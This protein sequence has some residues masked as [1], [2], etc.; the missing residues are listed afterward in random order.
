[1][2][3]WPAAFS[4]SALRSRPCTIDKTFPKRLLNYS[5]KRPPRGRLKR[6]H[7][8]VGGL[9]QGR[10]RLQKSRKRRYYAADTAAPPPP[11]L[12]D[13]YVIFP[14]ASRQ[15]LALVGDHV[16]RRFTPRFRDMQPTSLSTSR[17]PILPSW[18][19]CPFCHISLWI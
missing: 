12:L 19:I 17:I 5:I 13:R 7:D 6:R 16:R 1:M 14:Q 10:L 8:A 18:T 4:I 2:K 3:R 11:L 9:F 15:K